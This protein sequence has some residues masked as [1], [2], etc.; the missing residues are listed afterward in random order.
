LIVALSVSL[1]PGAG[2]PHFKVGRPGDKVVLGRWSCTAALPAL[3]RHDTVWVWERWPAPGARSPGRVAD[4]V[5]GADGL[6]VVA[7]SPGC[8]RLLV[9]RRGNKPV[10]IEPLS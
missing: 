10:V 9:T 2:S 6:A 1:G 8:D 7:A 5:A 4:R 3:L